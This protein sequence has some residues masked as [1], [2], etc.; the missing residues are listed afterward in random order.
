LFGRKRGW[1][2]GKEGRKEKGDG[3]L[4]QRGMRRKEGNKCK[5]VKEGG[6]KG[7]REGGREDL[8]NIHTLRRGGGEEAPD[9]GVEVGGA[10]FWGDQAGEG[11]REGG[12]ERG[13]DKGSSPP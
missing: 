4:S 7:G 2:G 1:K 5:R 8:D 12:G 10:V 11:G 13:T 9:E 3:K 6:R